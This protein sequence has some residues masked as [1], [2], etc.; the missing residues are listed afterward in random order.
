MRATGLSIEDCEQRI[1]GRAHQSALPALSLIP[2]APF[3]EA[4]A[5]QA[6]DRQSPF[7]GKKLPG[8]GV[9][10]VPGLQTISLRLTLV[11]ARQ[12]ILFSLDSVGLAVAFKLGGISIVSTVES[13]LL[14]LKRLWLAVDEIVHHD[15]VVLAIIIR[16]RGLVRFDADP[17]D[18]RV[19]KHDA[20]EGQAAIA[21]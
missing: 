12:L 5:W 14:L 10:R 15:N 4:T 18:A 7:R 1:A 2:F 8:T 3:A 20:E 19:L 16:T 17:S 9:Q 11:V 6:E 13:H 21:W